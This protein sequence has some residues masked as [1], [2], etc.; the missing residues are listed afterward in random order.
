MIPAYY[1]ADISTNVKLNKFLTLQGSIY[2]V[3]NNVYAVSRRPA[4]L[5][6]GMPISFRVGVKAHIY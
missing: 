1:V 4:G 6:P 2:N 5:R 3:F